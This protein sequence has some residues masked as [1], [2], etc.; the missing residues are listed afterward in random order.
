M[1]PASMLSVWLRKIVAVKQNFA[2]AGSMGCRSGKCKLRDR[3][4]MAIGTASATFIT[5]L[6]PA[7]SDGAREDW[8]RFRN[9]L[10]R[11]WRLGALATIP[12]PE[13]SGI[14]PPKTP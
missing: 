1:G 14:P 6:T 13:K 8:P 12:P 9:N 7:K 2:L 10:R 3:Q 4:F 5:I 11:G